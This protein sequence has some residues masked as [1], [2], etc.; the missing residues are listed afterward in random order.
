MPLNQKLIK[1]C[2]VLGVTLDATKEEIRANYL[3]LSRKW[4]PDKN[5]DK[6]D[7]ADKKFQAIHEAYEILSSEEEQKKYLQSLV[8]TAEDE[9]SS[10]VPSAQAQASVDESHALFEAAQKLYEQNQFREAQQNY[11][12][13]LAVV[14]RENFIFAE[15]RVEELITIYRRLADTVVRQENIDNNAIDFVVSYLNY[16]ASYGLSSD[17]IKSMNQEFTR[18]RIDSATYCVQKMAT[19]SAEDAKQCMAIGYNFFNSAFRHLQSQSVITDFDVIVQSMLQLGAHL[20]ADEITLQ[21]EDQRN[22]FKL[23]ASQLSSLLGSVATNSLSHSEVPDEEKEQLCQ[24][25]LQCLQVASSVQRNISTNNIPIDF[26]MEMAENQLNIAAA[27]IKLGSMVNAEENQN[28][29]KQIFSLCDEAWGLYQ[30]VISARPGR[31]TNEA[32]IYG[33]SRVFIM[34][35]RCRE[36]D[37]PLEAVKYYIK[38]L[39]KVSHLMPKQLREE[40]QEAVDS[41]CR[42]IGEQLTQI[43]GETNARVKTAF[44][45]QLLR[46]IKS[47]DEI[48]ARVKSNSHENTDDYLAV[49]F[50]RSESLINFKL[51]RLAE[52]LAVR[53]KALASRGERIGEIRV[54]VEHELAAGN[55]QKVAEEKKLD[56]IEHGLKSGEEDFKAARYE[57]AKKNWADSL[58][59]LQSMQQDHPIV[60]RQVQIIHCLIGLMRCSVH[61]HED[62]QTYLKQI[63]AFRPASW[64]DAKLEPYYERELKSLLDLAAAYYKEYQSA[65]VISVAPR[66]KM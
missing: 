64:E 66:K 45:N 27:M 63:E 17:F 46:L 21:V 44:T 31:K 32:A 58:T 50:S 11:L 14:H 52:D 57:K 53:K 61:T 10:S 8:E 37:N 12:Q 49:H 2:E 26:A 55:E 40:D 3:K 51:H 9:A 47:V 1:F 18:L 22:S 30:R 60:L 5:P 39:Q 7:E 25:A 4:H 65:G 13:Y 38:A 56:A 54:A 24:N 34:E 42:I 41:I 29:Q 15:N 35:A 19:L 16:D 62:P 36:Q 59:F 43:E 6:K 28:L 20:T 48:N 23:E 33:M